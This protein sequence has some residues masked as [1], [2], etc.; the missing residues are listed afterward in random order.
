MKNVK[1]AILKDDNL[2]QMLNKLT[3][4][5]KK[6]FLIDGLG[7]FLTAFFLFAILR[8]FNEYIGMPQAILT[9]L[10]IVAVLFCVY[11]IGCFFLVNKNW[12]PFLL[13]I[14]I[15]NLLYCCVT[16]GFIMYYYP[17]LT[18]LGLTYFLLELV[19]VCG[20]VFVELSALTISN[21][22]NN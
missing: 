10:S 17:Q 16:I 22:R 6:L 21:E 15:A 12:K 7:A 11:S 2:Q 20:L 14:S 13:A 9:K 8:T 3:L 18:S 5:T 4:S 1:A 19:V